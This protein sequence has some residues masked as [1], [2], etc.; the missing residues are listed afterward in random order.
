MLDNLTDTFISRGLFFLTCKIEKIT[1]VKGDFG[2]G[3]QC[4]YGSG[5][6]E[7]TLTSHSLSFGPAAQV[8][9]RGPNQLGR[10]EIIG[11][12]GFLEAP[13]LLYGL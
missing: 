12:V 11:Q 13:N 6:Q 10:M 8:L 2:H 9:A 4:H 1:P 3:G 7:G 5:G